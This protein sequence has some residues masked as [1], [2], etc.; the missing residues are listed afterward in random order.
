MTEQTT[1]APA[2][3]KVGL[4]LGL[5]IFLL[6]IAFAWFTLRRGHSILSRVVY[7]VWLAVI[8]LSYSLSSGGTPSPSGSQAAPETVVETPE[9]A[10]ARIK[11][12][13]ERN[14][15][16]A[17]SLASINGTKV[18]FETILELSGSIANAADFDIKDAE[19][20][21]D[22]YG[23]SGTQVGTV[24]QTLYEVIPGQTTKRF[25]ELSMGFMGSSQV[26]RYQCRIVDAA[27]A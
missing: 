17:L 22:L 5:G 7:F 9:A 13:Y 15:E 20:V 1:Q 18:G 4:L 11:R 19:I 24:R 10:A 16:T 8:V 2:G 12:G 3:R 26:A 27:S 6:P 25:R 23:P 14:P 21:C